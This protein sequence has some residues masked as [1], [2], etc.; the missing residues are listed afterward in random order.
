MSI[1]QRALSAPQFPFADI[2]ILV[3]FSSFSSL[4]FNYLFEGRFQLDL[5]NL[6]IFRKVWMSIFLITWHFEKQTNGSKVMASRN[7]L[8]RPRWCSRY[9]NRFNSNFDLWVVIGKLIQYSLQWHWF[10]LVSIVRLKL[11][12]WSSLGVNFRLSLVK[13]NK[14]AP[15]AWIRCRIMKTVGLVCFW[16]LVNPGLTRDT[17]VI[18]T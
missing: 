1:F 11:G 18:L 12:F 13:V 7:D 17:L 10:H 2:S 9:F 3:L 14:K 8:I 5:P 16:P 4:N 6:S 15:I